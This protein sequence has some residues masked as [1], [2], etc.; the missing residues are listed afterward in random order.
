MWWM[1]IACSSETGLNAV[2]SDEGGADPLDFP[3][4]AGSEEVSD[5]DGDN[6]WE[7][8]NAGNLPDQYFAAL[9][10]RE[11]EP[12]VSVAVFDLRGQVVAEFDAAP[13]AQL[14]ASGAGRFD[15]LTPIVD[16]NFVTLGWKV[17]RID[18]AEDT[19][20]SLESAARLVSAFDNSLWEVEQG[21]SWC[22][23]VPISVHSTVE[24]EESWWDVDIFGEPYSEPYYRTA[25]GFEVSKS[26]GATS[27]L[28]TLQGCWGGETFVSWSPETGVQWQIQGIGSA[29]SY[30][31]AGGG[32]ALLFPWGEEP[33]WTIVQTEGS[34][35][36]V[37]DTDLSWLR[38][39]P[40]LD[41]ENTVFA[42][43]GTRDT[44]GM[45]SLAIYTEGVEM[46]RIDQLKFG[47]VERAV[48]IHGVV[49]IS[50]E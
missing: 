45:D 46:W 5:V 31:A 27:A 3:W 4:E 18:L 21:E 39:G 48:R 44:D 47:F 30:T 49:A 38:P 2:K 19:L 8:L 41:V 35:G 37:V 32:T 6:S 42:G 28:I 23:V 17:Q 36:G 11:G 12:E 1:L 26:E 40:I 14:R 25:I 20:E 33:T 43:I 15:V 29:P 16:E 13:E 24:S 10:S 7:D 50:T 22:D 9:V 34:Y